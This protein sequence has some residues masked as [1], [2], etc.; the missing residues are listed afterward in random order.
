MAPQR[1]A[2]TETAFKRRVALARCT[3]STSSTKFMLIWTC[4]VSH[5]TCK[6]SAKV[7]TGVLRISFHCYTVLVPGGSPSMTAI[8]GI[9]GGTERRGCPRWPITIT[10]PTGCCCI[11]RPLIW[12]VTSRWRS[13]LPVY[14]Q[15]PGTWL[16]CAVFLAHTRGDLCISSP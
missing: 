1:P 5:S 12:Q 9:M 3:N 15:I 6:E 16:R 7:G 4:G 14:M 8:K 2:E 10:P 11:Q 13:I